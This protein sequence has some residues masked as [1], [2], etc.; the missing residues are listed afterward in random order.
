KEVIALD[1]T[2]PQP[3][4][5][6]LVATFSGLFDDVR[7]VFAASPDA[8]REGL[9][10][11]D[12]GVNAGNGRCDVCAGAGAVLDRD[13]WST[14]PS[15]GGARYGQRVLAVR[16]RGVNVQELLETPF[17]QLG[18]YSDTFEIPPALIGAVCELGVGYV[19]LGRR[20]DSLSGGEVQRLRLAM[21][22]ARDTTGSMLFIM[23]EPAVGLHAR[24]VH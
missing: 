7:N 19:A 3:N 4:R 18:P 17:A 16:V 22:L 1:Q 9:T 13:L 10:A 21:R 23:D 14:C 2:M 15:C 12:F 24:D 11:S 6:S 5:R 8:K 20:I